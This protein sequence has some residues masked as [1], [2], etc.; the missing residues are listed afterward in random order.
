[1]STTNKPAAA[2]IRRRTR[3]GF[4]WIEVLI[5][6][7]I[8][9]L[10]GTMFAALMP[11]SAKTQTMVECY[12]QATSLAQHK[13]DQLRAVGYGR[14][15]YDELSDAEIIDASPTAS[16][17]SFKTADGLLNIYKNATGTI[18]VSDYSSDIK[19]VV[20]ALTWTGAGVTQGNGSLTVTALISKT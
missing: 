11:M 1:M 9:A 13:I 18:T 19:Q 10:C 12:Q 3:R 4:T 5:S 7:A 17:F 15:T 16:P 2:R 6:I 20:V 14:L 8:V